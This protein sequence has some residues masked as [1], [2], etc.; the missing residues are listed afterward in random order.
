MTEDRFDCLCL[1]VASSLGSSVVLV[2]LE[3][4]HEVIRVVKRHLYVPSG[5]GLLRGEK[6]AGPD[7]VSGPGDGESQERQSRGESFMAL[8]PVSFS[9]FES[10]CVSLSV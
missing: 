9:L 1:T 4:R 10:V 2:F 5:R 8:F 3:G 7:E 6:P